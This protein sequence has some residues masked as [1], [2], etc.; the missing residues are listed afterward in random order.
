L[1]LLGGIGLSYTAYRYVRGIEQSDLR[2]SLSGIARERAELVQSALLRSTEVLNSVA[3]LFATREHVTRDEFREFVDDALKRHGELQ[4]LGWTPRLDAHD[5]AAIRVQAQRDGL[6]DF[7]VTEYDGSGGLTSAHQRDE[8]L[9]IYFIE[10]RDRNQEA[11]GFDLASSAVRLEAIQRASHDTSA[12][13]TAPM[14]LVQEPADQLGFVVYRA[15][16]P[17]GNTNGKVIGFASA[18]FRFGDLLAPA[19]SSLAGEG[20]AVQ[21]VDDLAPEHSVIYKTT[22]A[23]D[24][25]EGSSRAGAP[26]EA[27]GRRWRLE[28]FPSA[29]FLSAHE[30]SQSQFVLLGGLAL[31]ALLAGHLYSGFRRMSEIERRVEQRTAQLSR[32]V[33]ERKRAEEA[34]RLAEINFRSIVENSVEG[35]FQTTLD[36]KYLSANRALARIYG[37]E[38]PQQLMHAVANIGGQLYVDPARRSDFIRQIEQTGEVSNFESQI[39][40]RDASIIW[41]S[42]NA[43]LASDANGIPVHYEGTVVDITARK[44]AEHAL[45]RANDEL[46]DR[47]EQRTYELAQTNS[48]LHAEVTDRKRAEEEAA[49]A[50]RAKSEFLANMSHE[51]RT[52]MNAILGYAQLMSRDRTLSPAQNDAIRTIRAS[53]RHLIELIDD[54]L[55]LSK[56]EA[57]HIALNDGEFDVHALLRDVASML[58]QRCEQKS[59]R[60]VTEGVESRGLVVRGDERKLRQVLINLAGNAVKFTDNGSVTLSIRPLGEGRY[61]FEVRDSGIGIPAAALRGIFNPFQQASNS[62][63]RGGT[64]LGLAIA[65]R[66]VDLMGG[67]LICESQPGQGSR[68]HFILTLLSADAAV[69]A[70]KVMDPSLMRLPQGTTVSAIVVDDIREN[71]DVL[72]AMLTAAGITVR[73]CPSGET[74]LDAVAED[75]PDIAF[76][77]IMMPGMDGMETA[78]RIISRFGRERVRLVATSASAFSH[79]QRRYQSAGFEDVITKP[80]RCDRVYLSITAL[81]GI[82]FVQDSIEIPRPTTLDPAHL[83]HELRVRLIQAAD[84]CDITAIKKIIAELDQPGRASRPTAETLRRLLQKYDFT[85]IT[86]L[87]ATAPTVLDP[88]LASA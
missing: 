80:L 51:I 40:R 44:L 3:S 32:E 52:P 49:S 73:T 31:T 1:A 60:L 54:I 77:D 62:A 59:L 33:A 36:G 72:A 26:I 39:Y 66:H 8:Y 16:R 38:S 88:S 55:D 50:N 14:R 11:V 76:I 10:P 19:V 35:I 57:G 46:E 12:A 82:D 43:R 81:L 47:V 2:A 85:A 87:T 28:V 53:G 5:P 45:R 25:I 18:V 74:A 34:A 78:R 17:Q 22:V 30:S 41:I 9:P 27:A 6:T 67:Q 58:R 70:K 56:I 84:L 65:K 7:N 23:R 79:E 37:Y 20:L 29:T 86:R 83:P 48:A 69:A 63:G 64:G 42:E 61:G 24:I 15:V 4:A 68:F 75:P 13:A 71:R 21:I